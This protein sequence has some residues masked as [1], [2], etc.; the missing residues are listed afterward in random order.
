[1]KKILTF[2]FSTVLILI[3]LH[4][5]SAEGQVVQITSSP[6]Q[7]FS[8]V[9]Q[10]DNL[11]QE[12]TPSGRLGLL[13]FV[14][15]ASQKTWL[16]DPA[17]IDE[18][19]AMSNSYSLASNA[20]PIGKEIAAAWL[21]QLKK[22]TL[23]ND[24]V[25]LAYGNPD[26]SLANRLAP[27]ELKSYYYFGK[28]RLE[29]FL[30]RP[31]RSGINGGWSL[32]KTNLTGKQIK[33][34]SMNRKA[35]TRLIRVVNDPTLTLMRAKLAQ[36]L[37]PTLDQPAKLFYSKNATEV[38]NMQLH[39]LRI[40]PGKYQITTES[41]KLPVTVINDFPVDVRVSI[42]M[43]PKNSRVKVESLREVLIPAQSKKQLEIQLNVIAPGQTTVVARIEDLSGV[44]VS[45]PSL[46]QVNSTVID[47]RV[48]W[49]TTGAAILLLLAA[50]AQSVRRVR[51]GR[52]FED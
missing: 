27:S 31:V 30:G 10:N 20:S 7:D 13:V 2:F 39:K 5:A 29:I 1:M 6:H 25:A 51:K 26:V 42:V 21:L 38:V 44:A 41:A 18:V 22:T 47:K 23:G 28:T 36:L 37:S 8:G 12:L 35:L 52:K 11:S 9:F 3:P 24:V 46:L 15:L 19:V 14:P 45:Q 33:N 34:Y 17:L 40:N 43:T 49:F 48:T 16:I 50:I 4:L 32:G